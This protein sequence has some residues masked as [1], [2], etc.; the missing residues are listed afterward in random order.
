MKNPS[1]KRVVKTRKLIIDTFKKM[2]IEMDYEDITIKELASR[3]N[4]NRKT[5]YSHFE[6]IED[7]VNELTEEIADKVIDNMRKIGFFKYPSISPFTKAFVMTVSEN[8]E[9]YKKIIVA[10][11][12]RFFSRNVKDIIKVELEQNA[13]KDKITCSE[14]ELDLCCEYI[15]SGIAKIFK[16]WFENQR[17]ISRDRISELAGDLVFHGFS[18]VLKSAK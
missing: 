6:C 14:D 11:S 15:S 10:N 9:L 3:A 1:D 8:V 13:L 12:Y 5:F 16:L 17:G 4:I 18:S 2:I 7:I